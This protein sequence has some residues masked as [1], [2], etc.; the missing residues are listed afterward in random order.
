MVESADLLNIQR[1]HQ[2]NEQAQGQLVVLPQVTSEKSFEW[3]AIDHIVY[4]CGIC[5]NSCLDDF[6]RRKMLK[7]SQNVVATW[8]VESTHYLEM[9]NHQHQKDGFVEL[10]KLVLYWKWW[11]VTIK[12]NQELRSELIL[13]LETDLKRGSEFRTSLT[14]LRESRQRKHELFGDDENNSASTGQP[15]A[16]EFTIVEHSGAIADKSAAKAKPKPTSSPLSSP[17]PTGIPIPERNRIEIE[18]Q[19]H[20]QRDAQSFPISKRML[21]LLTRNSS[22]RRRWSN[23]IL[24]LEGGIQISLPKFFILVMWT[25]H[26]QKA[27]DIR[28]DFSFPL[29]LIGPKFF[30]LRAVLGHSGENNVDPSLLDNVLIP[31][32]FW[33]FIYLVGSYFNMHFCHCFRIDSGRQK[34]W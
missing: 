34:F 28:R 3:R 33:E 7:N 29:I 10:Q 16:K 30:Y 6:L 23:W 13:S 32:N 4:K 27:R 11:P 20:K 17:S 15:V 1:P 8:H 31:D 26:L 12:G 14:H 18:P 21:A 22:S 2:T 24:E 19:G 25:D 9:T 5:Q